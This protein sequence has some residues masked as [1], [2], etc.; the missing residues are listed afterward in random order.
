MKLENVNQSKNLDQ[1]V[2][3]EKNFVLDKFLTKFIQGG[4]ASNLS[5]AVACVWVPHGE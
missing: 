1:K 3:Q 4:K 5:S 2:E